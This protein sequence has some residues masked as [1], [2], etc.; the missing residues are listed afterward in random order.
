MSTLFKDRH[1]EDIF[2][3]ETNSAG[4]VTSSMIMKSLEM[5]IL[6]GHFIHRV[7]VART[8]LNVITHCGCPP[9][10]RLAAVAICGR[11]GEDENASLITSELFALR[12]KVE[13]AA[14]VV[15]QTGKYL[16]LA[17]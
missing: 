7:C 3:A 9:G 10:K 6:V 5:T 2:P 14:D 17:V 1:G 11:G 15:V 4:S 12:G 13:L 8:V 16:F